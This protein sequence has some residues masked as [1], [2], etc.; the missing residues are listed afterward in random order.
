MIHYLCFV[1]VTL[2]RIAL[3]SVYKALLPTM[4]NILKITVYKHAGSHQSPVHWKLTLSQASN[5]TEKH[6]TTHSAAI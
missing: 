5:H 2:V 6:S 1:G 4:H 3:D